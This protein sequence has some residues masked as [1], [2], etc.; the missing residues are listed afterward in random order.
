MAQSR[1]ALGLL[2]VLI[3]LGG[4]GYFGWRQLRPEPEETDEVP[5][6]SDAQLEVV[7]SVQQQFATDIPTPVRGAI[8]VRDTLRLYVGAKARA[9]AFREA[10]LTAQVSGV[11]QSVRV[12]ENQQVRAGE[13]LIQIDTTEYALDLAARRASLG[14]AE[15]DYQVRLLQDDVLEDPA[16]RAG[17]AERARYTTGLAQA[18]VDYQRAQLTLEK[19]R[20]TAPFGGRIADLRVVEGQYVGRLIAC[21]VAPV[22][23]LYRLAAGH[24][25]Y[26]VPDRYALGR[27]YVRQYTAATIFRKAAGR[28]LQHYREIA[29]RIGF[30]PVHQRRSSKS[31]SVIESATLLITSSGANCVKSAESRRSST[32][33]Y[34]EHPASRSITSPWAAPAR[35]AKKRTSP[36]SSL[37]INP[38]HP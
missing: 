19:T 6:M 10:R 31:V 15:V 32:F 35:R 29:S 3:I 34:R 38:V 22:Q 24:H 25:Q 18:E 8:A 23:I 27:Q 37:A 36:S 11:V 1:T 2:T 5:E 4:L 26:E 7:Q 20:V 16:L 9:E 21:P 33:E 17:R 13:L 14:R 12:R 30:V 28:M